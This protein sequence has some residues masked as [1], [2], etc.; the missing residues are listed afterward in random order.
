[1]P[2]AALARFMES[3][4]G[5]TL[6][7]EASKITVMATTI[8]PV[9]APWLPLFTGN[10]PIR[11]TVFGYGKRLILLHYHPGRASAFRGLFLNLG[12]YQWARLENP[13]H[14]PMLFHFRE[15]GV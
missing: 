1:M 7:T 2:L 12:P 6:A 9:L 14:L 15:G 3:A 13:Q 8:T 10:E 11:R 5:T 4:T